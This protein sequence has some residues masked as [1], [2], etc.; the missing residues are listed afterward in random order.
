MAQAVAGAPI[1]LVVAHVYREHEDD[2]ET[3]RIISARQAEKREIKRYQAQ[4]V[5]EG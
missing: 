5:D 4:A 2:E 1:L 3:I